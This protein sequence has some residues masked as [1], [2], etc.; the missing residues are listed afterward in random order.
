MWLSQNL[1]ICPGCFVYIVY[2][3]AYKSQTNISLVL[4]YIRLGHITQNLVAIIIISQNHVC[5]KNRGRLFL[6]NVIECDIYKY[7][8]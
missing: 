3:N 6:V 8:P 4:V 7:I 2:T 5:C 1:V